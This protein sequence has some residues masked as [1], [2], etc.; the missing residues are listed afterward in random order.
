MAEAIEAINFK[1]ADEEAKYLEEPYD[2][3]R[4]LGIFV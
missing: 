2:P 3:K 1:L 4:V